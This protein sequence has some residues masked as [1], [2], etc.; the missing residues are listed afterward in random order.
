MAR[1]RQKYENELGISLPNKPHAMEDGIGRT[2]SAKEK[3]QHRQIYVYN[4]RNIDMLTVLHVAACVVSL[5]TL[6]CVV[7][8]AK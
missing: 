4:R 8:H 5:V 6:L 2:F 7:G 3:T 1:H